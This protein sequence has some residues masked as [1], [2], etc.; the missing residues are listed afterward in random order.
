[1]GIG[2]VE[3]ALFFLVTACVV[4][5]V[6]LTKRRWLFGLPAFFVVAMACSPADPAST[7]LIAVPCCCIYTLALL[8]T[9]PANGATAG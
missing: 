1:M 9:K 3:L 6:K 5:A 8:K 4:V 7:L 2:F